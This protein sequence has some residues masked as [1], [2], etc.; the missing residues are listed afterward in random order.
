[1]CACTQ[2]SGGSLCE[3]NDGQRSSSRD[4][5]EVKLHV[6]VALI[7]AKELCVV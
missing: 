1:M 2:R 3:I 5:Q 7:S 6:T 4:K